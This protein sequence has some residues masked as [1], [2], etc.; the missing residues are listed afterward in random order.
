M[1]DDRLLVKIVDNNKKYNIKELLLNIFTFKK[2]GGIINMNKIE[3]LKKLD[4]LN[5]NKNNYCIIASGVMLMY[6]LKDECDDVDIKV[7]KELFDKLLK[8][9][10]MQQSDRYDYVYELDSDIDVN[11]K[12]FNRDNIE[13]VDGYPVESLKL[14][15]DWMIENKRE[16]DKE[17][18]EKIRKYLNIQ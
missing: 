7:S 1:H 3:F 12:N 11:C 9:Y 5:L 17:K 2:M 4:K 10:N 15:L 13:F 18:I 8:E 14:Q 16:K 6:G